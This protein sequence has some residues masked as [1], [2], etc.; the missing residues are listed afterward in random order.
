MT[1]LL[2]A[3]LPAQRESSQQHV[4]IELYR[5]ESE[6][7]IERCTA[8]EQLGGAAKAAG[9]GAELAAALRLRRTGNKSSAQR[10]R[11]ESPRLYRHARQLRVA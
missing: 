4:A 11:N 2:Q 7:E 10:L 6:A 1:A 8:E 9:A 3:P 5:A